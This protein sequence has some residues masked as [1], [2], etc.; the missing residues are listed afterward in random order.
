MDV[1][2]LIH[3]DRS[4]AA[5][6]FSCPADIAAG[7]RCEK[8]FARRSDLVRH[9]RIHTNER[10]FTCDWPGCQR[11]FIQRS[12]LTVHYRVH[13]GE[14]PHICEY[15]SCAKAFSDSSSLARHRRIHTGKRPYKCLV[16][17][18]LKTFCRKTTLTK[19]IKRNHPEAGV[20]DSRYDD[21]SDGE[22]AT[23]SDYYYQSHLRSPSSSHSSAYYAPP[24]EVDYA[25]PTQVY[26][27]PYAPFEDQHANALRLHLEQ[28]SEVA[29]ADY[30]PPHHH[31]QHQRMP[32]MHELHSEP[33]RRTYSE[34]I[35]EGIEPYRH[36]RRT[37]SIS[38]PPIASLPEA[39]TLS[40]QRSFS[41]RS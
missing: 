34:S 9:V 27:P 18:C 36:S 25:Y 41:S 24:P 29:S 37:S 4:A 13:T 19:H 39:R 3:E 26:S 33:H 15:R 7:V 20:I 23:S 40:H 16:K 22:A 31:P 35:D 30:P 10:P 14:R 32:S 28:Q 6:P 1:L 12:A 38:F 21:D 2:D 11:D 8:T 17:S 5:R